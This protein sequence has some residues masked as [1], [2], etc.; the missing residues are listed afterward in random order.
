MGS[1]EDHKVAQAA[2]LEHIESLKKQIQA[3]AKERDQLKGRCD[4]LEELLKS[5]LRG[6]GNDEI[7]LR[8][9]A[10]LSKPSGARSK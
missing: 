6:R 3:I 10:A 5:L 4:E 2:L 7:G 1:F 8:I 9:A